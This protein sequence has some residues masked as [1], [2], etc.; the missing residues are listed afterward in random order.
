[1]TKPHRAT[2]E[3]WETIERYADTSDPYSCLLE[4]RARIEALEAA[5]QPHQDKMDRLIAID[6]DDPANSPVERIA[7]DTFRA[8]CA[9]LIAL[10]EC[11]GSTFNIP[12]E[13]PVVSRARAALAEQ[14]VGPTPIP[15]A[16][17]L[18]GPDDCDAEGGCWWFDSGTW[19]FLS[20]S[21]GF[22]WGRITHWLPVNALPLPA[23]E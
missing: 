23:N 1:M 10:L 19:I 2:P 8:L 20:F 3:Q 17:R 13:A 12:I 16:E 18:P 14:P 15:V 5:Q 11:F 7:T 9:E 21:Q 6:R 4:L 22:S